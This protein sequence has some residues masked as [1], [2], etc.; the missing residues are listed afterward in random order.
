MEEIEVFLIRPCHFALYLQHLVITSK[1]R[2]TIEEATNTASWVHQ[3]AGMDPV[4]HEPL[5]RSVVADMQRDLAKRA[6]HARHSQT[7]G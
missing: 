4:G 3:L 2:A 7:D 6:H 5:I 1:S